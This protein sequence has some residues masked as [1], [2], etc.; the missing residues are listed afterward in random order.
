MK[1]LLLISFIFIASITE[2]QKPLAF[3][4]QTGQEINVQPLEIF[5]S[6]KSLTDKINGLQKE[7]LAIIDLNNDLEIIPSIVDTDQNGKPEGI[8]FITSGGGNNLPITGNSNTESIRTFGLRQNAPLENKTITTMPKYDK[9]TITYLTDADTYLSCHANFEWGK[10]IANTFISKYPNPADFEIYSK[11]RWNYTNGY[12]LNALSDYY[13]VTKNPEYLNYIKDWVSIFVNDKGELDPK[14]Y[15]MNDYE[16]DNILP[17][18]LLLFLYQQTGDQKYAKAASILVDQLNSQPKTSDG[19]FW[20]KKVYTNQMW[21][22]GIYMADVYLAQ[23][24][25]VF[26]QPK[27]FDE[28]AKQMVLIYHHT[29]DAKTGL[30]YHG[31]D[32][33]INKIWADPKTG[34]SPEFWGRALGWYIMALVDGLDYFPADHPKREKVLEILKNLSS[35][36]AKYQDTTSGLWYQV[37]DKGNLP[38]NW[39]ESSCSAMFAYAFAKGAQKGYLGSEYQQLALKA[40]NGLVKREVYFDGS[41]NFYLNG[42]VKVGTLNFKYSKGNYEYYIGVDRHI[43]DFKGVAPFFNL[44]LVLGK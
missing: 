35:S 19:G 14:K 38:G 22:D 31:W 9:Y 21:L 12:Y 32:E 11:G 43:N 1:Y 18:R 25:K 4:V 23:Y 27:Y 42:T 29:V 7:H 34:T 3:I 17:G 10:C 15:K 30:L 39:F 8:Y 2:A 40:F 5:L 33:S 36:L 44:A 37:V 24:A 20:H 28:A 26:N 16:L 13:L 6:W 41:G